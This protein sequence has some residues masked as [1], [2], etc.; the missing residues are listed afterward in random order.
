M[1]PVFAPVSPQE[2]KRRTDFTGQAG[3]TDPVSRRTQ[4][5]AADHGENPAYA[6]EPL[7]DGSEDKGDK[8]DLNLD[9]EGHPENDGTVLLKPNLTPEAASMRL[10]GPGVIDITAT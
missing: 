6:P 9:A 2:G 3:H 5:G 8:D 7:Q 4:G 1:R 10:F